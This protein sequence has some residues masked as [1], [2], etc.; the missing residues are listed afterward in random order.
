MQSKTVGIVGASG[1]VGGYLSSRYK[2]IRQYGRRNIQTLPQ[3]DSDFVIIA[4]AP[5]AKW[6]ANTEPEKDL[7]NIQILIKS[8]KCLEDKRTILISTIDVFPTGT[9]FSESEQLPSSHQ[10]GYGTNRGYLEVELQ[11]HIKNLHIV[12]LP[13]LFGPGLKKNLIF[14]LI[15]NRSVPEI[16]SQSTFQFY[17]IRNLPGHLATCL[18]L[19]LRTV[20]LATE[21][22]KVAEI[23]TSC[24]QMKVAEH[25]VQEVHYRMSTDYSE[26]LAG[27]KGPYIFSKGEIL[28]ALQQW[29]SGI[30]AK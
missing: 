23:Y 8:L 20:N 15:N 11:K 1:F 13:G 28:A 10:E 30:S 3:D 24:F 22:V 7:E 26:A 18:D 12:R 25:D 21:P 17:D 19:E 16:H 4:A 2:N 29:L 5:A 27:R 6:I 14:D 9:E